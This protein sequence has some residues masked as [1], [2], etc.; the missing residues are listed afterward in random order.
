M[1][2]FFLIQA[3]RDPKMKERSNT[4]NSILNQYGKVL[5][6]VQRKLA[7]ERAKPYQHPA[8]IHREGIDDRHI[9]TR[10]QVLELD[11]SC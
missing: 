4:R 6:R 5:P 3:D 9:L 1:L 2:F 7:I 8:T 10:T 11:R